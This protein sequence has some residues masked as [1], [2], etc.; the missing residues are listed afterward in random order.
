[1]VV[2]KTKVNACISIHPI[3]TYYFWGN[4]LKLPY[5]TYITKEHLKED[6]RPTN[7]LKFL[8]RHIG[9]EH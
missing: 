5:F 8:S 3:N 9:R 2:F 7:V 6:C 1:M 4:H